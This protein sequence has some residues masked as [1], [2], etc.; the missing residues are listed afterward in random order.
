MRGPGLLKPPPSSIRAIA[1]WVFHIGRRRAIDLR[2]GFL[3]TRSYEWV[4]GGYRGFW[5]GKK[6]PG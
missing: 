4:H 1:A 3:L 2:F 5:A 6:S